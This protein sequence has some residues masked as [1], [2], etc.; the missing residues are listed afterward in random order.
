MTHFVH[1]RL[2]NNLKAGSIKKINK[3]PGAIAGL[4]GIIYLPWICFSAVG[5]E[6]MVVIIEGKS[7]VISPFPCL[8]R[9]SMPT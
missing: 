1:F 6:V 3:L 9:L 4:V 7:C 2:L 5:R 8:G